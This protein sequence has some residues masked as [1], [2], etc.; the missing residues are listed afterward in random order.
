[1]SNYQKNEWY[2]ADLTTGP[3]NDALDYELNLMAKT[4]R[5]INVKAIRFPRHLS[6]GLIQEYLT[7]KRL[8]ETLTPTQRSSV[9]KFLSR[10]EQNRSLLGI[11]REVISAPFTRR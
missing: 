4:I 5:G 2:E 7:C 10:E 9:I 11:L 8:I 3:E 1:M 6:N